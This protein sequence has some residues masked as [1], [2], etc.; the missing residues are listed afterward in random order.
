MAKQ[1]DLSQMIQYYNE[2][3]GKNIS[4]VDKSA[5]GM[6]QEDIDNYSYYN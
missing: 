6:I 1:E 4:S 3:S 5:Y 2:L